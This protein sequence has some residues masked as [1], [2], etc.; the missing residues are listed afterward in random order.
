MA[1]CY[2][3]YKIYILK[4]YL[5]LKRIMILFISLLL[6][7]TSVP[8]APSDS[9]LSNIK[10]E[11]EQYQYDNKTIQAK[12][13]D[14]NSQVQKLD[15]EAKE[16]SEKLSN[17][18]SQIENKKEEIKSTQ[19]ELDITSKKLDESILKFNTYVRNEYKQDGD[20]N[21]TLKI[22][23]SAKTLSDLIDKLEMA[24]IIGKIN[25]Q[26]IDDVTENKVKI[27]NKTVSLDKEKSE[28][29]AL[30]HDLEVQTHNLEL[31]QKNVATLVEKAVELQKTNNEKLQN[32]NLE[33]Q[34]LLQA[35]S[36]AVNYDS[37]DEEL[38]AHL[39]E[40]EAGSESYL[41]KLAVGSVVANRVRI[42][43]KSVHEVIYAYNQ[44]D[45]I[46]TNNFNIDPSEDSKKAAKEVLDGKNVVPD[47]Y[48][49][50]NLNLCS[51]SFAIVSKM[52]IRIG[53]HWFFK[54]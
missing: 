8:A 14:L 35:M 40:S 16:S 39:I 3:I 18:K 12:I 43:N 44:F 30:A 49:Y 28:L 51:P 10:K 25:K 26:I 27:Q 32:S 52:V 54:A 1:V 9:D 2:N 7:S 38:L 46:K 41:G 24:K 21:P 34:Q 17:V 6:I 37:S 42:N 22:L 4:E 23:F 50:A 45:G 31:A 48:Y 29:E 36:T 19:K 5:D 13:D 53:N 11:I 20:L 15:N 33:Y 47:A